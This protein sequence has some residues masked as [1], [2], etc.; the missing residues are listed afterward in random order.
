MLVTVTAL[1]CQSGAF[2]P[3]AGELCPV[4]ALMIINGYKTELVK[5]LIKQMIDKTTLD[6]K[7]KSSLKTIVD[8]GSTAMSITSLVD[9]DG[10][11][12]LES[13]PLFYELLSTNAYEMIYYKG[14]LRGAS[15]SV[16]LKNRTDV[17]NCSFYQR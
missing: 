10:A 1:S 17:L 12:M 8:L 16:P 13:L 6:S 7:T 9:A 2:I 4:G 3:G 15:I 5:A 14:K 11:Q